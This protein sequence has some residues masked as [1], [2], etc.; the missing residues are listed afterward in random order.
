MCTLL[1]VARN[2]QFTSM[3]CDFFGSFAW[4]V[5]GVRKTGFPG[6]QSYTSFDCPVIFRN[7]FEFCFRGRKSSARCATGYEHSEPDFYGGRAEREESC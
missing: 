3:N 6:K 5:A 4:I 7:D 1:D 2:F